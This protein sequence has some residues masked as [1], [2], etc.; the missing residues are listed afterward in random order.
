[1]PNNDITRQGDTTK[2]ENDYRVTKNIF[3]IFTH[4]KWKQKS[5]K[6]QKAKGEKHPQAWI[7]KSNKEIKGNDLQV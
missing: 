4:S 1:M 2:R 5:K 7:K 3:T 6:W